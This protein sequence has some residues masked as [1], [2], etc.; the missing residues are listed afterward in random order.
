MTLPRMLDVP[1]ELW[2]VSGKLRGLGELFG[3]SREDPEISEEAF[4][5]LS[6]LLLGVANEIEAI[7]EAIESNFHGGEA[8]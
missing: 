3:M 4:K 6:Y 2:A 5:G 8:H 7:R 1:G